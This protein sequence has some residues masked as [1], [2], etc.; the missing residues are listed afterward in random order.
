[1]QHLKKLILLFILLFSSLV[2]SEAFALSIPE[3]PTG[4]VNDYANLLSNEAKQKLESTL[5]SF[6]KETSN[7]IIIA[8]FESLEGESLEDYS[9]RLAKKWKIG[10][11]EKDNGVILLFFKREHQ[12]RIEVGY[13]LEGV[14][15]DAISSQIIRHE[16]APRFREGDFDSGI[17]NAVN[18]IIKVT[19]GEYTASTLNKN[20]EGFSKSHLLS[21]ALILY[22]LFPIISFLIILFLCIQFLGFPIGLILGIVIVIILALVRKIFFS[23]MFGQTIGSS[24]GG[25][26]DSGFL[27]GGFSGGS[28]G[29][30]FIGGGGG[31][32]GGGASGRW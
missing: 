21:L 16:I 12:V 31:F 8:T 22:V 24:R 14:L 32:G 5:S 28:F 7:Q 30:G 3:K 1:M 6:K 23:S 27:G 15:P 25:F 29:G 26:Y 10:T 17:L 11:K 18:A 4:Y 13:G 2:S 19:K 20:E 9:I